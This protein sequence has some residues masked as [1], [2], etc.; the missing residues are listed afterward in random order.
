[1]SQRQQEERSTAAHRIRS[2]QIREHDA[3]VAKL[4]NRNTTDKDAVV[5]E[6]RALG[7]RI[8]P[9][10]G[11]DAAVK[12]ARDQFEAIGERDPNDPSGPA[13]N[14]EMHRALGGTPDVD[15][16][17]DN[18]DGDTP[19]NIEVTPPEPAAK[20]KMTAVA[21]KHL[22][23]N[24]IDPDDL[25]STFAEQLAQVRTKREAQAV[26][27][28]QPFVDRETI[29]EEETPAASHRPAGGDPGR[30]CRYLRGVGHPATRPRRTRTHR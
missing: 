22:M 12:H 5:E 20:P 6:I 24:G 15:I 7:E 18:V 1:M 9:G 21:R 29:P 23:D 10:G 3:L 28:A 30:G 8:N 4:R 19:P 25:D 14:P 26:I 17:P 13:N 27:D 16:S 2:E 11:G